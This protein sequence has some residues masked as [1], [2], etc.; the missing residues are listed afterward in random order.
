MG[1]FGKSNK[2]TRNQSDDSAYILNHNSPW[3]IQEAYKALR[4]NITFSLPNQ[5]GEVIGITSAQQHD[6]KSTVAIN[7]AIAFGEI[8]KKV[9]LVECDMRL[10][11]IAS[12]LSFRSVPGLADV[13]AGQ[14][15]VS[16]A[17][18]RD[19]R[20]NVDVIAAGTIPPDPTWLLQSKQMGT[21]IGAMQEHYDFIF[22]DT[23]PVNSVSDAM[24]TSRYMDGFLLVVRDQKTDE[25][26]VEEALEQ[27]RFGDAKVLGFVYFGM[28]QGGSHY[29]KKNGYYYK[30]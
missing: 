14:A 16:E 7:T 25:R 19:V 5:K 4:T 27:M 26:A 20:F 10:P 22:I 13:L 8:G 18:H 24:I 9:L 21:L 29:Y 28:E 12:R 3:P 11:V 2:K 1:V 6:G 30:K 23:P 15:K 17:L